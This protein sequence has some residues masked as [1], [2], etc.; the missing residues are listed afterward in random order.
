[1]CHPMIESASNLAT[2]AGVLVHA[3]EGVRHAL[4]AIS[5]PI[6]A[7]TGS[8]LAMQSPEVAGTRLSG[9]D[10]T[11]IALIGLGVIIFTIAVVAKTVQRVSTARA[12][13]QSRREIAAYV[14]EGSITPD[15]AVKMMN[16]GESAWAKFKG[17]C[18]G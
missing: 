5:S 7:L 4:E 3:G 14:A 6:L 17:G 15:D 16:A 10:V 18:G 12:R 13:E 8:A 11:K 9:D 1:M 2:T